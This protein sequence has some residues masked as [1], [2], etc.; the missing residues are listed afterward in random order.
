MNINTM[1]ILIGICTAALVVILPIGIAA[2]LTLRIRTLAR[3]TAAAAGLSVIAATTAIA[4][5]AAANPA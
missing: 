5:S 1:A 4:L 2:A 3:I